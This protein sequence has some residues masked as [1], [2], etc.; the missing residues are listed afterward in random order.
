MSIDVQLG[1]YNAFK[2][3]NKTN[4]YVIGHAIYNNKLLHE[5]ELLK[6]IDKI[7]TEDELTNTVKQL[8]GAFSIIKINKDGK[9]Y[10]ITDIVGSFPILY[11]INDN[12]IYIAT[13]NLKKDNVKGITSFIISNLQLVNYN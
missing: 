5:K 1:N 11:Q 3:E 9:I 10:L 7:T 6:L 4:T 8:N 12:N 13:G 2:W